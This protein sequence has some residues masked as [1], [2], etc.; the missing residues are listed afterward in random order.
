MAHRARRVRK[1]RP[2]SAWKPLRP[3]CAAGRTAGGTE[4]E[5]RWPGR[6]ERVQHMQCQV[7]A[8]VGVAA[9]QMMEVPAGGT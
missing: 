5:E 4:A 1:R 7:H 9:T 6:H 3:R 8:R 2:E